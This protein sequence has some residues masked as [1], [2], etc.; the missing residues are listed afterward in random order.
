MPALFGN[1][2]WP[3]HFPRSIGRGNADDNLIHDCPSNTL[4]IYGDVVFGVEILFWTSPTAGPEVLRHLWLIPGTDISTCPLAPAGEF[5]EKGL[6]GKCLLVFT[7]PNGQADFLNTK[8][9]YGSNT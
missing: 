4:W 1:I 9:I 2:L 5:L 3:D 6:S 8:H 7:C